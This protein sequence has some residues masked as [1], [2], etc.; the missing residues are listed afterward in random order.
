MWP[1]TRWVEVNDQYA[2]VRE[3]PNV[4]LQLGVLNE[5]PLLVYVAGAAITFMHSRDGKVES[6]P[7]VEKAIDLLM[8]SVESATS[9]IHDQ[10]MA[11][12]R[13]LASENLKT[14]EEWLLWATSRRVPAKADED[15]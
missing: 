1:S 8:S 11:V 6:V 2:G 3:S 9:P 5:D 10:A 13:M 12:L 7:Q 4:Q 15:E 14:R